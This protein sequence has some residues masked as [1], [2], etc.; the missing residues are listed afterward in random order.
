MSAPLL[1]ASA[2]NGAYKTRRQHAALPITAAQLAKT[3]EEV[4]CAGARMIH[5]HVRDQHGRH[6]LDKHAYRAAVD[7]LRARVGVDF[8]I[9]LT[10]ESA[11]IYTAEQQRRAITA[12]SAIDADGVSI[13]LREWFRAPAD[14][15]PAGDLCYRLSAQQMLIQYILFSCDDI[16]RYRVLRAQGVIPPGEH[17]VLLVAGRY[18]AQPAVPADLRRMVEALD[19]ATNGA[20]SWM[21][22][23]F[24]E[25]EFDC[26]AEAVKLGG[27]VRVGLENSLCLKSGQPARDNRQLVAQLVESGNPDGRPLAD[28]RQAR[29]ILGSDTSD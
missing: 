25:H 19:E 23:A 6:T 16:S 20:V 8:F 27:H 12:V 26:L 21:A 3:A 1:I 5:L 10:S 29:R 7:A 14:A 2:P 11:D 13:A 18:G 28:S 4:R 17:S 9:Q 22:C 15:V 24:G